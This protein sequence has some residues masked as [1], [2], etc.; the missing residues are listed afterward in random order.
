MNS[1]KRIDRKSFLTWGLTSTS[2]WAVG[3]SDDV[4][5]PAGT[6][7]G[8]GSGGASSGVAG[9]GGA[10]S[11]AAG[12][13]STPGGTPSGGTSAAAGS[14]GAAGAG[15][16]GTSA[17]AANCNAQL[18]VFVTANHGHTFQITAADVMAGAPKTYDTKGT[19]DHEHWLQLTAADFTK[20]QAGGMVRKLSCNDGHEHEFIVNCLGNAMPE[21]TSGIAGFC[22][23]EHQC[24]GTNANPCPE[25]T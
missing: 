16:G 17:S 24:A 7:G 11:G 12:T 20:L 23:T 18:A 19:S 25:I 14:S 3:C 21:T 5:V 9:T 15:S 22:D 6:A 2:L 4:A 8:A 13:S 1:S 10:T